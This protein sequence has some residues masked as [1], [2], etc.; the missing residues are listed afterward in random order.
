MAQL[1]YNKE[2]DVAF[3][4]MTADSYLNRNVISRAVQYA[5]IAFG[6]GL[7]Y[8]AD[9]TKQ[10]ALP[11]KDTATLVFDADFVTSNTIDLDVNGVSITQVTFTTDHDTTAG[12]L[13]AAIEA[14]TGVTCV[15]DTGDVNNRTFIITA[16]GT[17][18]VVDNV[19]VAAGASQAGSTVTYASVGVFAGIAGHE[20][21][22]ADSDGVA[23]YPVGSAVNCINEGKVYVDATVAVSYDDTAYV[24]AGG[25]NKGKWTNVS[26]G[27]IAT[28]GKFKSDT[29]AA[30]VVIVKIRNL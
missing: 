11:F 13:V 6:L 27:N 21:R 19:V 15:L 8:G 22:Q 20:H 28:G 23:N 9:K 24:I 4:G 10:V 25:A 1:D 12:L 26:T 2:M 17:D 29:T 5:A 18:I 16:V 3:A 30:G 7:V 14:L